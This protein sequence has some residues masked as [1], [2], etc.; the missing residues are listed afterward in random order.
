MQTSNIKNHIKLVTSLVSVVTLGTLLVGQTASAA[1]FCFQYTDTISTGTLPAG[2]AIGNP[3][4]ILIKADNGASTSVSQ[5][6]NSGD[7]Q[8]VT[9]DFNNGTLSTTFSSGFGGGLATATGVFTTDGSSAIT[10]VPSNW[11]DTTV[12]TDFTTNGAPPVTWFISGNNN[13]YSEASTNVGLTNVA[14]TIIASNWALVT[15]PSSAISAP[16]DLNFN[17]S[18]D[19]F[20]TE[21]NP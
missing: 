12:G 10:G 19:I 6:W 11:R 17:Q 2:L 9:F 5:T 8:A 7:L 15:C 14:N 13:V 1:S 3:V 18:A 20:S 16:L 21:I 4:K